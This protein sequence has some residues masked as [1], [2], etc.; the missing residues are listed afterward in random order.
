MRW[1]LTSALS[2]FALAGVCG[3]LLLCY[4][5]V[6]VTSFLAWRASRSADR[7]HLHLA[8]RLE[9]WNAEHYYQLG[10]HA[11]FVSADIAQ[12]IREFQRALA[13]NP[14]AAETWL[15]LSAAY[16][17]HGDLANQVQA[18]EAALKAEPSDP[19]V[20]WEA[21]NLYIVRGETERALGLF[22]H[23]I[24]A[25]STHA[26]SAL[27]LAWRSTRSVDSV[28]QMAVPPTPAARLEFLKLLCQRH[29]AAAADRVWISFLESKPRLPASRMFFY[30]D[31][32]LGRHQVKQ[33]QMAWRALADIDTAIVPAD[34]ENLI[35]NGSFDQAI[36]NGGFGWR[37]EPRG[38][39]SILLDTTH[40]HFGSR[41]LLM[42]FDGEGISE[43][44]LWQLVPVEPN[45][46]YR[47]SGFMQAE[48]T[49]TA[50]GPRF[51]LADAYTHASVAR[52]E[53]VLGST[54]WRE[55]RADFTTGP[56]SELLRIGIVRSPP[57]GR[58][59]GR[60]WIDDLKLSRLEMRK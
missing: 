4:L 36:L 15:D 48:E 12:A 30:I 45:S 6:C 1:R 59:R 20:E 2:R 13:L 28:L 27:D 43:T 24:A 38:G 5:M 50:S 42:N 39:V 19:E 31:D 60:V 33:A 11:F 58:I 52:S 8:A 7:E 29:E 16:L 26:Q 3:A 10:R 32:L 46:H 49:E 34:N 21:G 14:Y 18:L 44:G 56:D 41:S 23:L 53:D 47:F 40:F 9:P 57:N 17:A 25:G 51:E 35:T 55:L 54:P 22:Q 37:Y